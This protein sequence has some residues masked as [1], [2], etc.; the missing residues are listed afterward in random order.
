MKALSISRPWPWAIINAGKRIENRSWRVPKGAI[1]ERIAIHAAKS[2]DALAFAYIPDCPDFEGD[3]PTGIVA[4]A[5]ITGCVGPGQHLPIPAGQQRWY[6]G[7]FGWVLDDV[8]EIDPVP[9][10]GALGLWEIPADV[11]AAV[12]GGVRG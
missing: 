4:L 6:F 12:S 7:P 10:K 8:V 11:L 2:V 1:G 3:H 5:T 9:C